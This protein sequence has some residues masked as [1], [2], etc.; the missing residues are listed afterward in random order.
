MAPQ[1]STV[2]GFLR[3][4]RTSCSPESRCRR[5]RRFGNSSC[6]STGRGC[7]RTLASSSDKS[8]RRPC[9]ARSR[10]PRARARGGKCR[11]RNRSA[12][13]GCAVAARSNSRLDGCP[14]SCAPAVP[15]ADGGDRPAGTGD[16]A[17]SGFRRRICTVRGT[18]E[19]APGR[20]A[21]RSGPLGD[22][23]KQAARS[24]RGAR[25][26]DRA[27]SESARAGIAHGCVRP[28][29]A[30]ESAFRPRAL[31]CRGRRLR[32]D[33]F[34]CVVDRGI[35]SASVA[36]ADSSRAARCE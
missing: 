30:V 27:R 31:D 7:S 29:A 25:R 36:C 22:R 20:Q 1:L 34:R 9:F 28:A 4:V 2:P 8:Q 3:L 19:A 23:A 10:Q 14:V 17:A 21:D 16:A 26:S 5:D 33:G 24:G 12:I 6:T 32:Y 11:P 18:R 35:A 13:S 15:P